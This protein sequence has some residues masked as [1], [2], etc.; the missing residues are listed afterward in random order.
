MKGLKDKSNLVL[1]NMAE[2][3]VIELTDILPIQKVGS[4]TGPE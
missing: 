4:F 1:A 2:R 3:L